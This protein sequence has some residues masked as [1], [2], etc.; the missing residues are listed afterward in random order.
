M[1]PDQEALLLTTA[2]VLRGQLR[3]H[4]DGNTLAANMAEDWRCMNEA[5]AP[6]GG[7]KA[8]PA[9]ECSPELVPLDKAAID[10]MLLR[11]F[12]NAYCT[13]DFAGETDNF[14]ERMEEAGFIELAPV[15]RK[16][17]DD[18]PFAAELGIE[19]GGVCW[20]LTAKGREAME[21]AA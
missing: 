4:L 9:N 14:V 16:I 3:D 2:R 15:T 6:F 12:W 7:S 5:L 19:M 1:K 11:Q 10:A 8:E 21:A 20:Q 13:C 17:V 18:E